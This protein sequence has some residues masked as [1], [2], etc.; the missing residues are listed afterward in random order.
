MTKDTVNPASATQL[1]NEGA[2]SERARIETILTSPEASLAPDQARHL[3]FKTGTA[4]ADAIAQLR[5][6][7]RAQDTPSGGATS[8]E[9]FNAQ[10]L[11]ARRA[12][13]AGRNPQP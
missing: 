10:A 12:A 1:R 3:A 9:E 2:L 4:A 5:R 11:Y 7:P 13:E 6:A 8:A